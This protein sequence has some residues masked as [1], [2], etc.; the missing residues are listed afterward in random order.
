MEVCEQQLAFAQHLAFTCLRFLDFH[1]HVGTGE[2]LFRG[3]HDFCTDGGVF[4]IHKAGTGSGIGFNNHL[5]AIIDSLQRGLWGQT[6][7][8]FLWFYF[9]R[10]TDQHFGLLS[11]VTRGIAKSGRNCFEI[12]GLNMVFFARFL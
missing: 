9:L 3:V 12:S 4:L 1:N 5:V 10:A 11:L 7:A 6:D 2:N 8:K